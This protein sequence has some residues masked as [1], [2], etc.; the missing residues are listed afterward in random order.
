MRPNKSMPG[1]STD[2]EV[3]KGNELCI[4]GLYRENGKWKLLYHN[5]GYIFG[6][7]RDHGKENGNPYAAPV[8]ISS[9]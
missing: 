7:Y 2:P 6:L 9:I 8:S 5:R 1:R 3:I 4:L